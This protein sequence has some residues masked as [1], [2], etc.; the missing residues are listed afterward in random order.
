M[1]DTNDKNPRNIPGKYYTDH[2]C[3]DC[4]LCRE[5][6]PEIFKR[7]DEEGLTYVWHQPVTQEDFAQAELARDNCPTETIGN[8]GE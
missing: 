2:S 3:I 4:D 6:A 1:A 8:D 7:D 5:I